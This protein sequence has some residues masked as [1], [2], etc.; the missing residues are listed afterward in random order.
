[1]LLLLGVT[2]GIAVLAILV[3]DQFEE[4]AVPREQQPIGWDA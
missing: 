1:M 3:A 4:R 2:A